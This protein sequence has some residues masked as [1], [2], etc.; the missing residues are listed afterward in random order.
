MPYAA[1]RSQEAHDSHWLAPG[2]E[3]PWLL[4]GVHTVAPLEAE[5]VP[6]GQRL[7]VHAP[8]RLYEPASQSLHSD[9][10]GEEYEPPSQGLHLLPVLLEE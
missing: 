5:K 9:D 7:Q 4:Q 6:L 3:N 1:G 2:P 8:S 10:A